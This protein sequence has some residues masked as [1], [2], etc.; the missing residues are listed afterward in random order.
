[1]G[2]GGGSQTTETKTEPWEG[3]Q[4]YLK[5]QFA[6]AEKVYDTFN[7]T[8]YGGT[9]VAPFSADQE[10]AMSAIRSQA[11]GAPSQVYD[12][13]VSA[14]QTAMNPN[15]LNVASNPYVNAMADAA[16]RKSNAQLSSNL[17]GVRGS[18]IR[19]GGYGGSRQGIAEGTAIGAADE[20]TRNALAQIYGDAYGRGMDFQKGMIGQGGNLMSMGFAPQQ[21][22]MAIGDLQRQYEQQNIA[23]QMAKHQFE[24]NLPYSKLQQFKDITAD[25]S[26]GSQGT[27]T[28]PQQGMGA[29]QMVGLGLQA[30]SLF[31]GSD[32][33]LKEN[34]IKTGKL[35]S[36]LNTYTW[37]WS[38]AAREIGWEHYPTTGVMAQEVQEVFPEAVLESPEGYLMVDYGRIH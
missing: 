7:P 28:T 9:T 6:E 37:T 17:A 16:V 22:L 36:G 1:M 3:Q 32:R 19:S 35:D 13:A 10:S 29:E 5:K 30:A 4:P 33:R 23:N 15:I 12:P 27:Q 38:K 34:I 14:F 11:A 25:M 31:A 24:Q 8:W 2:K 26:W 20:S 21:K 18:A